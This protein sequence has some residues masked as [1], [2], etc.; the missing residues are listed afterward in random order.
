MNSY[1]K[2]KVV[3]IT[4]ASSGIGEHLAYALA[5][6]GA[7][8][9]LSSRNEHSLNLVKGNCNSQANIMILPLDVTNFAALP[10]AVQEVKNQFPQIDILINNAGVSQRALIQE[11]Q[12]QVDQ[13]IMATNYLG[14]VALT[15]AVLP[16][17]LERKSGQIVVIS[18]VLGKMSIP[19]R[20]GYAASK[21]ALHGYF[22]ALRVEVAQQHI[23]VTI[24][25]PGYVHTNVTI[26]ALTGDGSRH[27]QMAEQTQNG[28]SPPVFASKALQAIER[29]REEVFIGGKERFA[30]L[31]KRFAPGL[32]NLL[33]R[34]N[35]NINGIVKPAP[36]PSPQS[37]R[38]NPVRSSR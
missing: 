23:K 29:G 30:V 2:N 38:D 5:D 31:L 33:L 21:H 34:K 19:L 20:S 22:D 13:Q 26:N 12:F 27:N 11:T 16:D 14:P 8:L 4:G 15:K 7:Q 32:F 9:I 6:R 18:S 25:C 36:P 37:P 17:M 10:Q 28:M 3:W 35:F 1:F 24:I